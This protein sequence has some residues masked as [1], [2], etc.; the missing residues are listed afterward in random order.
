[1]GRSVFSGGFPSCDI[2]V[3]LGTTAQFWDRSV[4]LQNI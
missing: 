4:T 2:W 1:V 3:C